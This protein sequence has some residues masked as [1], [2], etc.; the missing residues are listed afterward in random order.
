[1]FLKPK[2]SLQSPNFNARIDHDAPSM[3]ILHYTGMKTARAALDRLC[4]PA[5]EVSAHYV[6]E[7]NGKTH[8]LVDDAHRAW[9]AGK[10]YWRGQRDINSAS[11]GIE[12]VNPGHE[13][14]YR[15]FKNKQIRAV[16]ELCQKLM[17]TYAI[18]PANILA[19]SDIAP[20]RKLDPGHLFPWQDLAAVDIG[21][22][23]VPEGV[24]YQAAEDIVL[25]H[26][27]FHELL[28][29]LG[30]DPEVPFEELVVAYHRHFCPEKFSDCDDKP[31]EP[32]VLSCARLLSLIRQSHRAS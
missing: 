8:Q 31:A 13:F 23:P 4:D 27:T 1:M 24:D 9:H 29:A 32:D 19:H 2:A 18:S 11:I 12:I 25:N 6:I 17:K 3:I 14:G 30:Y 16:S 21:L 7:Q 20:A 5:A 15:P 10:A 26:T 28:C 22:W